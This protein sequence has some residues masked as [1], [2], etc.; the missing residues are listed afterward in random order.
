MGLLFQYPSDA[1]DSPCFVTV[2]VE[3]TVDN[4]AV[5]D[6]TVHLT[7]PLAGEMVVVVVAAGVAN[8]AGCYHYFHGH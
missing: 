6:I 3:S 1:S 4:E 8:L 5:V 7:D 2:A